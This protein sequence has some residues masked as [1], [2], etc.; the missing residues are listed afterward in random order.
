MDPK[1]ILRFED[2]R[3]TLDMVGGKGASLSR[4]V[5]AGLPVPEGFFVTTEAYR[6]FVRQNALQPQILDALADVDP[7]RPESLEHASQII[8]NLFSH[9]SIPNEI[10]NE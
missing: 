1:F 5:K 9:A 4:M 8:T 7:D 10:A 3:A 2:S 6:S